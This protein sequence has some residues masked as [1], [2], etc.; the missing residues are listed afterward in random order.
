MYSIAPPWLRTNLEV[1]PMDDLTRRDAL[2]RSAQMGMLGL[3]ASGGVAG[4]AAPADDEA[5]V[6][7]VDRECVIASGMTETEADC[8]EQAG[9]LAGKLLALPELHPMER[10]EISSAIHIIQY[11]LLSRPTYRKYRETHQKKTPA[12][13]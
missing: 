3:L 4:A 6:R 11:R 13:K 5:A 1:I 12:K 8:W 10:Q 9:I 2:G 7:A